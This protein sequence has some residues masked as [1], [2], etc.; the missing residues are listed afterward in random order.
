MQFNCTPGISAECNLDT[1]IWQT[2]RVHLTKDIYFHVEIRE[3]LNSLKTQ[4]HPVSYAVQLI[5][6]VFNEMN[7]HEGEFFGTSAEQKQER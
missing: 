7:G 4:I 1:E 2:K 3:A 6:C 5:F